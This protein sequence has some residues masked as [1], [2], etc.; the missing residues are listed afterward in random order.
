MAGSASFVCRRSSFTVSATR[1]PSRA[2]STRFA[3]RL[4]RVAVVDLLPTAGHSP[5]SER[6]TSDEVT[7]APWSGSRAARPISNDCVRPR[8]A[9]VRIALGLHIHRARRCVGDDC[10]GN[11]FGHRRPERLWQVDAPEHRCRAAARIARNGVGGGRAA[12]RLE[13]PRHLHVSAGRPAAVERRARK[14]RARVDAR[15]DGAARGIGRGR[16]PGC[17]ASASARSRDISPR[18]FPAGCASA[19]RWRRTGSSIATSC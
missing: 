7:R 9:R 4:A 18:S 6:A 11:V 12:R 14:R 13:S 8:D 19:S 17:S 3:R 16:T 2:S 10:G 15:R 1:G 5:H